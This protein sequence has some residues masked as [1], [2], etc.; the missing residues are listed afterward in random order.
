MHIR[1]RVLISLLLLEI[2]QALLN[3][4]YTG[5]LKLPPPPID[6]QY[7]RNF[8]VKLFY[9]LEF[10]RHLRLPPPAVLFTPSTTPPSQL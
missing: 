4:F 1:K 7:L 8:T 3:A 5:N 6:L 2:H 10:R 9:Y